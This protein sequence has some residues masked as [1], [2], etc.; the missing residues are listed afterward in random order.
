MDSTSTREGDVCSAH[1]MKVAF[2]RSTLHREKCQNHQD[3]QDPLM[4]YSTI[5]SSTAC[6]R[7]LGTPQSYKFS[8]RKLWERFKQYIPNPEPTQSPSTRALARSTRSCRKPIAP[9]SI[10]RCSVGS[11]S[12]F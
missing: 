8:T 3:L 5:Q 2:T 12:L 1:A 4:S 6:T 10:K 7:L 11:D 9:R